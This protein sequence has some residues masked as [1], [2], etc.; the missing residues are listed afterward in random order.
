MTKELA[1]EYQANIHQRLEWI[2][3]MVSKQH[4]KVQNN[5]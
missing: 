3:R 5:S 1:I 4:W 2:P